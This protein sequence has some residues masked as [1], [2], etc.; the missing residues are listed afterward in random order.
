MKTAKQLRP[1][2]SRPRLT[3]SG[4]GLDTTASECVSTASEVSP[5]AV[6]PTASQPASPLSLESGTQLDAVGHGGQTRS[7]P[8]ASASSASGRKRV[9]ARAS[10]SRGPRPNRVLLGPLE[11]GVDRRTVDEGVSRP[12]FD[13]AAVELAAAREGRRTA[14]ACMSDVVIAERDA[15]RHGLANELTAIR[16]AWARAVARWERQEGERG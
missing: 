7:N 3:V 15:G 11:R 14:L 2:A 1:T 12:A 5:D 6:H 13:E 16:D 9:G 10:A 8:G 4:R